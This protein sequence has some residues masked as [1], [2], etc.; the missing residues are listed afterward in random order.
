MEHSACLSQAGEADLS[1]GTRS[2][3]R[4]LTSFASKIC[5]LASSIKRLTGDEELGA[6]R[7]DDGRLHCKP[8][9]Y[10]VGLDG[11]RASTILRIYDDELCSRSGGDAR[12]AMTVGCKP[13]KVGHVTLPESVCRLITY[14]PARSMLTPVNGQE[15]V[16][17][18]SLRDMTRLKTASPALLKSGFDCWLNIQIQTRKFGYRKV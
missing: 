5:G 7:S 14:W 12:E 13:T 4:A 9:R 17:V 11:R 1:Q 2:M 15:S 8:T 3:K 6:G 16:R 18:F 10:K